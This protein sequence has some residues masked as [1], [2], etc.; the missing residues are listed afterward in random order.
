[1]IEVE[2][3]CA[4]EPGTADIMELVRSQQ[5]AL[6]KEVEKYCAERGAAPPS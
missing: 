6:T 3:Y 4:D 2:Q 1:M 5:T